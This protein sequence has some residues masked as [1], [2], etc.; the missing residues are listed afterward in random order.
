MKKVALDR[1]VAEVDRLAGI[2]VLNYQPRQVDKL[3]PRIIKDAQDKN[4]KV[5]ALTAGITGEL[6]GL[7]SRE[8]LRFQRL[9]NFDIDFSSSFSIS[10]SY[11]DSKK[12]IDSRSGYTLYKKDII[13]TSRQSKGIVLGR[14]LNKVGF[15]PRKIVHI[16]NRIDKISQVEEYCKDLGIEFLGIHY[17]RVYE[18]TDAKLDIVVADKKLDILESKSRWI[19]DKVASCMVETCLGID[20]CSN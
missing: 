12:N 9:K 4:I 6:G 18:I 5:I 15:K 14:F 17:K 13:F 20:Q 3:M 1:G 7:R 19:S 10:K 11:L 16:D 2:M 8:N